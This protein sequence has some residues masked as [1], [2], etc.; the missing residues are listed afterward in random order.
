MKSVIEL[1]RVSTESQAA[2][3][4]AGVPAQKEVN[5]KT[6]AQ[7]RLEIVRT[8]E[9]VDV[10]GAL[11]LL[12]PE[13]QELLRLMEQPV[14]AGVVAREF[15]RLM[16]PEKFSDFILLQHFVDTNTILY[17]PDGPVDF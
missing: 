1:V 7:Y 16:R 3:D 8:I 10:S 17:L 6:A 5:A 4:R 11:V 9:I 15:S 13:M 14:I 2:L 12:A